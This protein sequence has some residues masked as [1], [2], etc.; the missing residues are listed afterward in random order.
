LNNT[1]YIPLL[2]LPL[3]LSLSPLHLTL[4]LFTTYFLNR[5]CIYCSLLLLILFASSCHWS[6]RCFVDFSTSSENNY[7][8]WF[9]PR[10]YTIRYKDNSVGGGGDDGSSK[11]GEDGALVSGH[12]AGMTDFVVAAVNQTLSALAGA[13]VQ[14]ARRRL[15]TGAL[16]S[17][18]LP[19]SAG[20]GLGWLRSLLGRSEWTVPCLDV[21]VKL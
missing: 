17:N 13:A 20:I 1:S 4:L 19:E 15:E 5:P 8:E 6:G 14:E 21:K 10:I 2:L 7:A 9:T 18:I 16:A 12:D 11:L 3:P